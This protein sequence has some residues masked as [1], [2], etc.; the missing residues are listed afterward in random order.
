ML[1]V[2][3]NSHDLIASIQAGPPDAFAEL[4]HRH[5]NAVYVFAYRRLRQREA[6]E[7]IT[8]EVFTRALA[9]VHRFQTVGSVGGWLTMIA[10]NLIADRFKSHTHRREVLWPEFF[11]ADRADV[12]RYGNPEA[13]AIAGATRSAV[14]A[15]MTALTADQQEALALRY[16]RGLSLAEMASAMGR[17]ETAIKVLLLRA[18]R[19]MARQLAGVAGG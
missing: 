19:S 14:A 2:E 18:R 3:P 8:Q 17:S 12:R 4:Y 9:A 16:W 13:S 1:T 5:R 11:D 6:A 10:R 7:D 15:A